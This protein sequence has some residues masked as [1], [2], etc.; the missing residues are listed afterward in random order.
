MTT[1]NKG[2]FEQQQPVVIPQV[3]QNKAPGHRHKVAA[4]K[5]LE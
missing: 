3:I 1:T 2:W 5:G 4:K